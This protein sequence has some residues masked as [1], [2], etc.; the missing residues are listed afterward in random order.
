MA[1]LCVLLWVAFESGLTLWV[2]WVF[3]AAGICYVGGDELGTFVGVLSMGDVEGE[4]VGRDLYLPGC[5]G[6]LLSFPVANIL[7]S[8]HHITPPPAHTPS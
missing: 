2:L 4:Y 5:V 3:K 1:L 6:L 7:T 8:T